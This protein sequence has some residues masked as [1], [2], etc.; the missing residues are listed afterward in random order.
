MKQVAISMEFACRLLLG[1]FLSFLATSFGNAQEV[2]LYPGTNFQGQVLR[3]TSSAPDLDEFGYDN[4]V[5]SIRILS[6]Q[7]SFHRDDGFQNNNGPALIL[8][9]GNYADIQDLN[10]PRNRMSSVQ[11]LHIDEGNGDPGEPLTPVAECRP[12]YQG[13]DR[14]GR[15]FFRCAAGTEPNTRTGECS[16]LAGHREVGIDDQG[17]RVCQIS[18]AAPGLGGVAPEV[19]PTVRPVTQPNLEALPQTPVRPNVT[20]LP[21][22]EIADYRVPAGEARRVAAQNGFTFLVE[23]RGSE[24]VHACEI[25]NDAGWV[26]LVSRYNRG[27]EGGI[28]H[29]LQTCVFRLFG[30]RALAPG[31]VMLQDAPVFASDNCASQ[32]GQ[33]LVGEQ[34]QLGNQL[35]TGMVTGNPYPEQPNLI[36]QVAINVN[37]NTCRRFEFDLREIRLRGPAGRD[38]REA[39]Q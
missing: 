39:F 31:W 34:S 24:P 29:L 38:W 20:P 30:A 19:S 10:F 1:L 18:G 11:L 15:C 23:S 5:S 7:W 21:Q 8:G 13:P 6:G 37:D 16:C 32:F 33:V 3:L 12:P 9:P 2:E 27:N 26:D 28:R 4:V 35:F 22:G 25:F 36:I 14:F 17:R